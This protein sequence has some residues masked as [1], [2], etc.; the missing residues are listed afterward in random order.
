MTRIDMRF[1]TCAM[2]A[3]LKARVAVQLTTCRMR[4]H[5]MAA[6]LRTTQ[7]VNDELLLGALLAALSHLRCKTVV[8]TTIRL[9][10]DCDSTA[11]RQFNDLHHDR[12]PTCGCGLLHCDLNK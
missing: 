10:L 1:M 11:L 6:A 4:G 5:T 2:T 3:K 12:T 8:T 9:P 7:L